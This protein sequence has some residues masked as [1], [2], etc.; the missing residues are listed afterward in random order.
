MK[1]C[2]YLPPAKTSV[3]RVSSRRQRVL[4][5]D[6]ERDHSRLPR[7]VPREEEEGHPHDRQP[8]DQRRPK[9]RNNVGVLAREAQEGR[10]ER[11]K[12]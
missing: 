11:V 9:P 1:S 8:E 12:R 3:V 7:K 5:M 6:A 2:L 10:N 4:V